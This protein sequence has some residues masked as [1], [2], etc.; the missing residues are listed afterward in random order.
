MKR[1]ALG[2]LWEGQ[3]SLIKSKFLILKLPHTTKLDLWPTVRASLQLPWPNLSE[4]TGL[5]SNLWSLLSQS[6]NKNKAR[7]EEIGQEMSPWKVDWSPSSQQYLVEL[8][9]ALC[10]DWAKQIISLL[11]PS[12]RLNK[13]KKMRLTDRS[14]SVRWASLL[15]VMPAKPSMSNL[16]EECLISVIVLSCF[17]MQLRQNKP[18]DITSLS[19]TIS[20]LSGWKKLMARTLMKTFTIPGMQ[21]WKTTSKELWQESRKQLEL[22]QSMLMM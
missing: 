11:D 12:S 6:Q 22:I 16:S 8:I 21:S 3:R 20:S 13:C 15:L 7:L 2:R 5:V 1:W 4:D 9:A 19:G 17:S 18:S 10:E 14:T